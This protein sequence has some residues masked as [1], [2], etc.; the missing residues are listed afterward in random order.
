MR[1]PTV[2]PTAG[3]PLQLGDLWPSGAGSLA[4]QLA[5]WLGVESVQLECS[6]TS[7]L[8]VALRSLKTL[9]PERSEVVAPA[10]TC[11]LVALAIAQCGLQLRLCDLRADALDMDPV[12]LQRLCSERTLAV[13]PRICVGVWPMWMPLCNARVPWAPM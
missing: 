5:A 6:G 4:A 10:Y 1:Q 12:C 7:A 3:L 8:M 11:P 9:S 2:P 13:L